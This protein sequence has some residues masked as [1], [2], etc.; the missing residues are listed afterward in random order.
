M[1]QQDGESE[2]TVAA[3]YPG[4]GV[5]RTKKA[6]DWLLDERSEVLIWESFIQKECKSMAFDVSLPLYIRNFK[7]QKYFLF[8]G[9]S[10]MKL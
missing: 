2:G 4:Q 3:I 1:W 5:Q 9:K 7:Q 6:Q 8:Q 10:Y